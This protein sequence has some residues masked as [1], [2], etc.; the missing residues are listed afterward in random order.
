MNVSDFDH[1]IYYANTDFAHVRKEILKEDNWLRDNY[2]EQNLVIENQIGFSVIWHKSGSLFGVGGLYE[3]NLHVGRH[4]NRVYTF[5]KWRSR[6]SEELIRNFRIAQV[7]M[8]EPLEAIKQFDGYVI[9]MQNRNRPNKNWWKYWKKNAFI[10]LKDW[11]DADGYMQTCNDTRNVC[12]QNYVFKG[13]LKN[14]KLITQEEW[15]EL[16]P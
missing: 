1:T 8:V 13:K 11:N 4:L 15:D 6:K 3:L 12:F 10:G 2:T 14:V 7:H 9:T 5:P 16:E